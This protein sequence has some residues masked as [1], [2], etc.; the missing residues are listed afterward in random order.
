MDNKYSIENFSDWNKFKLF[1]DKL[2]DNWIFRGQSNSSWDLCTL[3][4]RTDFFNEN[5]FIETSFLIEY[6]R[7]ARNYLSKEDLPETLM[8]WLALMQHHGAPTRLLDFSKSPFIASYFAFENADIK[9]ES[10]AIWAINENSIYKCL[11]EHL[12][13]RH[14]ENFERIRSKLSDEDYEKSKR[15]LTDQDFI[16][17]FLKNSKSCIIPIEPFKM[18]RRY[19]LQ[20]SIFLSTGNSH[21]PFMK[22]LD[23]LENILEKAVIKIC[24][25]T[26]IKKEVLR[27]LQKMNINRTTLFPDLDGYSLGL[28][29][30]YNIGISEDESFNNYMFLKDN[31]FKYSK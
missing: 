24:L 7:G 21:E 19:S 8:E 10:V 11:M 3:L 9:E 22:Q 23:F 16:D 18:N 17:L 15:E 6:Q 12:K 29:V 30:R 4:E 26:S 2:S 1:V 13:L 14:S 31:N 27:D 5:E 20:Q 25:P 28:K